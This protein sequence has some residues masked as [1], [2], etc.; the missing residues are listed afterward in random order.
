MLEGILFLL[1]QYFLKECLFCGNISEANAA[2]KSQ[3]QANPSRSNKSKPTLGLCILSRC[4]HTLNPWPIGEVVIQKKMLGALTK[5]ILQKPLL[6][7][8][9]LSFCDDNEQNTLKYVSQV[10]SFPS[11]TKHSL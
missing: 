9:L 8:G 6:P 11:K 3:Q 7:E 1:N 5:G 4:I 10:N 2:N